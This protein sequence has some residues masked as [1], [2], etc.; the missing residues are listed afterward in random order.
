MVTSPVTVFVLLVRFFEAEP[1]NN[2]HLPF[3]NEERL[4]CAA[5]DT[6]LSLF[7]RA[8]EIGSRQQRAASAFE[9]PDVAVVKIELS[10]SQRVTLPISDDS[11]ELAT[12]RFR[13]RVSR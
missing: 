5:Q 12:R 10:L 7:Q 3:V 2:S 9:G 11:R 6:T 4:H 1:S 8:Q 13:R